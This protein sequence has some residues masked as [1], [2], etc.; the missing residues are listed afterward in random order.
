MMLD[1]TG[2]NRTIN[3]EYR[4]ASGKL[5]KAKQVLTK[6]FSWGESTVSEGYGTG[7]HQIATTHTYN[8]DAT[9]P[10]TLGT[11]DSTVYPTGDWRKY[12]YDSQ[13]R[14]SS[15]IAP[16]NDAALGS[17]PS[18][19]RLVSH[20]YTP[21]DAGDTPLEFDKRPRKST[22]VVGGQA[23]G[24]TYHAYKNDDTGPIEITES[25]ASAQA[26]YG[27]AGNSRTT[28]AYYGANAAGGIG[29]ELRLRS[30]PS[31]LVQS[32]T[33]VKT[34]DILTS[35]IQNG[36]AANPQGVP[37]K[38][39]K[40]VQTKNAAGK[41]LTQNTSVYTGAGYGLLESVVNSY[42]GDAHLTS[43]TKNGISVYSAVYTDG[44]LTSY[45]DIYG[46]Q[47]RYTYDALERVE[48]QTQVGANGEPD[49]VTVWGYNS[50][51]TVTS[52][53]VSSGGLQTSHSWSFDDAG[54]LSLETREDG[55][56][57]SYAY[58]SG[59]RIVTQTLP[60]G[61]T[62]VTEKYLDGNVKS[63][64]GSAV[65]PKFYQYGTNSDGTT[66]SI[67]YTGANNSQQWY[68]VS[69]DGQKRIVR[70]EYPVAGQ[71]FVK[72]YTYNPA[73][74]VTKKTETGLA[75]EIL[76]Y[77]EIGQ[78]TC[79]GFDI[80]GD[81]QLKPSS[82]DRIT[83]YDYSYEQVG[84]VWF[85]SKKTSVYANANDPTS[86]QTSI[87]RTQVGVANST[88]VETVDANGN[89]T[90]VTTQFNP[91]SKQITQ[92][93]T[94]PGSAI[95][96][97]RI[98]VNNRVRSVQAAGVN[99]TTSYYYD[100]L[101]RIVQK[102]EP[103][104]GSTSMDYMSGT[105][106]VHSV[107]PPSG[108]TVTYAYYGAN[109]PQAGRLQSQTDSANG[110]TYYDYDAQGHVT[111]TW[112][113]ATYPVEYVFDALGHMVEQ[114][115]FRGGNSW[116]NSTWPSSA[117]ADVTAFTYDPATGLLLTR[118]NADHN[119]TT[120]TYNARGQIAT[121]KWARN[122]ITTYGYDPGTAA[123]VSVAYSD[124]TPSVSYVYTRTGAVAYVAD[125]T[126]VRD[127]T[128]NGD[129][130]LASEWI[131]P[132]GSGLYSK[133]ITRKYEG[134]GGGFVPGRSAGFTVVSGTSTDYDTSYAYDVNGRLGQ[135]AGPG[136]PAYGAV[137]SYENVT[138]LL[139]EID[140]KETVTNDPV[141]SVQRGYDPVRNAIGQVTNNVGSTV[142]SQYGYTRNTIGLITNRT[143]I[144]TAFTGAYYDAIA[145]N[146]R[147]EVAGVSLYS[148]S[149]TAPTHQWGYNYDAIGNRLNT[150]G[151][152]DGATNSYEPNAVNQYATVNSTILSYDEDGNL[153]NDGTFT[154]AWDGENRLK[155]ATAV[156]GA[157]QVAFQYDYQGRR[158]EKAVYAVS[159]DTTGITPLS[160]ERYVY[161]GW[162]VVEVLD[163]KASNAVVRKQTW[164]QDLGGGIGGLL[165]VVN[166]ASSSPGWLYFYDG[167]G[168]VG[169]VVDRADN[170][171]VA[172]YEYDA[173]GNTTVSQG[174]ASLDNSYRFSTKAVDNETGLIYYGYR[175]YSPKLG[176]WI[177]RDP[178]AEKGGKNLYAFVRN[179]P[180][181]RHDALGLL[182]RNLFPTNQPIH[183]NADN[184]P[185]ND[186]YQV[187][188]HGTSD[189]MVGPDG[190][191]ISPSQLGDMIRSDPNY[192]SGE[193]VDLY[194]C[195]TG[196]GDN[197][198]AQQLANNLGAPVSAP[199]KTLWIWP[200]G[201]NV[202]Y[203]YNASRTGPDYSDPGYFR[204]F[205]PDNSDALN[206]LYGKSSGMDDLT[207]S[208]L[209]SD[210]TDPGQFHPEG[211]FLDYDYPD[212]PSPDGPSPA[213]P[214][215]SC[216]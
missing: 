64:T 119:I 35:T 148:G 103:R 157:Q 183:N 38:T 208:L 23:V 96:G 32:F 85:A 206:S 25:G 63:I 109:A 171:I 31:G 216:H 209:P 73:G 11:V 8:V 189:H 112:G 97:C 158:V 24:V 30:L 28:V 202:P 55:G 82:T 153:T 161:N 21:V 36:S 111:R 27:D 33:H 140:Y 37:Y 59:G 178:I 163:G 17:A 102:T 77:D 78:L 57:T 176:R 83:N 86:T 213:G 174:S 134:S 65:I 182:D 125:A 118:A 124:G 123:L 193:P 191:N 146:D 152:L 201:T 162:N 74:Q 200:D 173:Y 7:D 199:D 58:A 106:Q 177:S 94:V 87:V 100:A 145:Y 168:N 113:N 121:R 154:Y 187:G 170:S 159:G 149:N 115:T 175:Y 98:M 66:F 6:S 19:A 144:G 180:I 129:L 81:G 207:K 210:N 52:E 60:G 197:S 186:N 105:W 132:D 20:D 150:T 61:A 165:S 88:V 89:V 16:L 99:G 47:T 2:R 90:S 188:G 14:V 72:T 62:V 68:K 45:T 56:A 122:V 69:K 117:T 194:S 10:E 92:I 104:I 101:G 160:V 141:A 79:D 44:L 49:V 195:N 185:S 41:I 164:G 42:D 211:G 212:K 128:Y 93:T 127:F 131:N 18:A 43:V 169:Q 192:S 22:A 130:S 75:D 138:G 84:G 136:L 26:Q 204:D 133:T 51:G 5:D 214:S 143:R 181:H 110:V 126:G 167:F 137:Y 190:T 40:V 91:A 108:S 50:L 172:R 15:E 114:H 9:H 12:S 46:S 142:I 155:S 29:G 120:Y 4:D 80:D 198:F 1:S 71:T 95:T 76:Q 13:G 67:E 34:G 70:E 3:W 203:D 205:S 135:V 196:A 147:H 54:R 156:N 48:T 166:T 151:D 215:S 179:N 139:T 53:T 116:G 39:T 107:T 184:I